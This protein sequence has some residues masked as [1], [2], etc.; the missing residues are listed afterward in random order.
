M[1][2]YP[3]MNEQSA[4]RYKIAERV[5]T[6]YSDH[7]LAVAIGVGGSVARGCADKFSDVEIGVFWRKLPTVAEFRNLMQKA[8]GSN[9]E[10]DPFNPEREDVQYEEYEVSGLKID[11]RHMRKDTMDR[12]LT[13]TLSDAEINEDRHEIVYAV[14]HCLPFYGVQEFDRWVNEA[15]SFPKALA[16]RMAS[17]YLDFPAASLLAMA[18]ERE[19][20]FGFSMLVSGF[21]KGIFGGLCGINREFFPGLKW[22]PHSMSRFVLKPD[23][24]SE[25]I[26]L[27]F[28]LNHRTVAET[29]P[30]LVEETFELAE[31]N[32]PGLDLSLQRCDLRRLRPIIE[33]PIN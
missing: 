13:A 25:R 11:L 29:I 4:W 6:D 33:S 2:S 24:I 26:K 22:M 9:W 30:S 19:D 15:S 27:L 28:E 10:L 31:A 1:Q 14:K 23:R 7:P 5:A 8:G 17:E 20:Q 3:F 18:I 12:V 16:H 21:V 32:L